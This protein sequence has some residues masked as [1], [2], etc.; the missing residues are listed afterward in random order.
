M[1][2]NTREN[3]EERKQRLLSLDGLSLGHLNE[4]AAIARAGAERM[5]TIPLCADGCGRPWT[6]DIVR[7]QRAVLRG[8][9]E[10][11][12]ICDKCFK[13]VKVTNTASGSE[14]EGPQIDSGER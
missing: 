1:A 2:T 13:E 4:L 10:A 12:L 3:L 5:D 8:A 11:V 14:V 7:H 6:T 9:T